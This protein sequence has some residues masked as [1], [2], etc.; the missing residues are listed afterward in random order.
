MARTLALI[1]LMLVC[2]LALP[3]QRADA[4]KCMEQP[5]I[6][7]N[8]EHYD[9]IVVAQVDEIKESKHKNILKLK[10]LQSFKKVKETSIKVY[11]NADWGTSKEGESYLF[12]LKKDN[13][14]W[15]LPLCSP[16]K[17]LDEAADDLAYLKEREIQLHFD[18]AVPLQLNGADSFQ[19]Q[20]VKK[21]EDESAARL[22]A[23]A[24]TPTDEKSSFAWQYAA[25]PLGIVGFAAY[26]VIRVRAAR[27]GEGE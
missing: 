6:E 11:E 3:G 12:Y 19:L 25:I 18:S 20:S 1:A 4:L 7:E 27:K 17:P 8:A 21:A 5:N 14:K 24:S 15:E 26:G 22:A 23:A 9:G 10:V 13:G 16:T 2:Y